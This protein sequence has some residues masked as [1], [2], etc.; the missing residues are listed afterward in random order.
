MIC[1]QTMKAQWHI[2]NQ[3]CCCFYSDRQHTTRVTHITLKIH[4]ASQL[5]Y[6][7]QKCTFTS[8]IRSNK[9]IN[10]SSCNSGKI[11]SPTI[12]EIR[13]VW[14]CSEIGYIGTSDFHSLIIRNQSKSAKIALYMY[15][16]RCVALN[17]SSFVRREEIISSLLPSLLELF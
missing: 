5:L 7:I 13:V 8:T 16:K 4:N 3:R 1:M 2:T 14:E 17:T 11:H 15:K 6:N 10:I 12:M 9:N